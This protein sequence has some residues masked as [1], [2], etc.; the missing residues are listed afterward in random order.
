MQSCRKTTHPLGFWI[1]NKLWLEASTAWTW[2]RIFAVRLRARVNFWIRRWLGRVGR[3]IIL[4]IRS[5]IFS[6]TQNPKMEVME[7]KKIRLTVMTRL[8]WWRRIISFLLLWWHRPP[9]PKVVEALFRRAGKRITC[10]REIRNSF[11]ST[12]TSWLLIS[13]TSNWIFQ[14]LLCAV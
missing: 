11:A 8:D 14:K 5:K 13:P 12:T 6:S 9:T 2:S 4:K 1:S 3:L 10:C 7:R